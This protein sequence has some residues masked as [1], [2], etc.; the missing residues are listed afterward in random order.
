[1]KSYIKIITVV[2]L[3]LISFL[4][5]GQETEIKKKEITFEVAGACKMCKTRIEEGLDIK[6]VKFAEWNVESHECKVVFD[7]RKISE[8]DVH[9]AIAKVGHDTKKV[10]AADE[11]YNNLH[12]CCHYVRIGETEHKH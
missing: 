11:D 4:S 12:G 3:A 9:K 6:G 2:F 7:P 5:N 10:K 1:M 8:E